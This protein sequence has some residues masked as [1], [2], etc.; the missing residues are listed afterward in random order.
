MTH[1]DTLTGEV[2]PHTTLDRLV[3]SHG[4]WATIRALMAVLLARRRIRAAASE[5]N[6]HLRRD[7]GLPEVDEAAPPLRDLRF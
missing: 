1:T 5:L 7:V 2:S 6:N 4:G 3:D